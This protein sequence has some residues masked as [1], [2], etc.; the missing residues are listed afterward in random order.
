MEHIVARRSRDCIEDKK[1]PQQAGFRPG[2]S[3]PDTIM[4]VAS[5]VWHRLD[6]EKTA[7]VFIDYARAFDSVDHGCILKELLSFGVER[8]LVAW[9]AG[10]LQARA[11][12]V[13]ENNVLSE[14]I[15]LTC[16]VPQ[17]SVL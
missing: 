3:T 12:K 11:A 8:H 10:F 6:G 15:G 2:R 1:R 16:G 9:T 17:G 7:A 14:D 5:A 13:R 4:Q